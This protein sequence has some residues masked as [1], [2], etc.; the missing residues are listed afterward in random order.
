MAI[1]ANITTESITRIEPRYLESRPHEHWVGGE[2][3]ESLLKTFDTKIIR[4]SFSSAENSKEMCQKL[5]SL[6]SDTLIKYGGTQDFIDST[7]Q[8]LADSIS[9]YNKEF[10]DWLE[11]SSNSVGDSFSSYQSTHRHY[12][13]SEMR[14][15]EVSTWDEDTQETIYEKVSVEWHIDMTYGGG[16]G[17]C[18]EHKASNCRY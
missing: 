11:A 10:G 5:D 6:T 4:C 18:G 13:T 12:E 1:T 15:E 17:D 14:E 8:D 16:S 2:V 9:M 3:T 7:F